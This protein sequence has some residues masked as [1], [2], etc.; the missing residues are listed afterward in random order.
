MLPPLQLHGAVTVWKGDLDGERG[1]T[2]LG[3]PL[4]T[5]LSSQRCAGTPWE[6]RGG[7][8]PTRTSPPPASG[9]SPRPPSTD[10]ECGA[11][12]MGDPRGG[13]LGV[14]RWHRLG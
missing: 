14:L 4:S 8:S 1:G 3:T 9:P 5:P 6:C 12:A 13:P 10:G 2:L 11:P 7:T